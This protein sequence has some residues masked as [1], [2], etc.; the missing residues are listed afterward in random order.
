MTCYSKLPQTYTQKPQIHHQIWLLGLSSWWHLK[1]YHIFNI[2]FPFSHHIF[3]FTFFTF[4]YYQWGT[5]YCLRPLKDNM[6]M[7]VK[8]RNCLQLLFLV[9]I[10]FP[11]NFL[12]S[13]W[14]F[15]QIYLGMTW[16]HWPTFSDLDLFF[17][18]TGHFKVKIWEISNCIYGKMVMVT[19]KWI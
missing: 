15:T 7:M 4:I 6:G 14:Y 12:L 11:K 1:M 5:V 3:H 18:V 10:I 17:K 16:L 8:P 9:I 19:A 2:F 13:Q